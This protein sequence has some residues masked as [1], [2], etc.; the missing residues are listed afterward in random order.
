MTPILAVNLNLTTL[1]IGY[2][3]KVDLEKRPQNG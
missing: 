2:M 1:Q 3:I